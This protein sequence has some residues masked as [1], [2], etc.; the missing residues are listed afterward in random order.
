MLIEINEGG[1]TDEELDYNGV[2]KYLRK[3]EYWREDAKLFR[4]RIWKAGCYMH[5]GCGWIFCISP[6]QEG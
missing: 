6:N 3:S 5:Y 2:L 1:A 4:K